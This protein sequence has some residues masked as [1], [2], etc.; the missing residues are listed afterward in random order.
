MIATA[1]AITLRI[2]PFSRTSHVVT[3]L[4]RE[5][6]P[7]ATVVKGAQRPRSDFLGQYD[8]FYTCEILFYTRQRNGLHILRECSP[9]TCRPGFRTNWRAAASASYVAALALGVAPAG[10]V[11]PGLYDVVRQTLDAME[12]GHPSLPVLFWFELHALARIG[13]TPRFNRC[14]ACGSAAIPQSASRFVAS[15]GGYICAGCPLPPGMKAQLLRPDI[16]AVLRRW[17]T[18]RDIRKALTVRITAQQGLEFRRILGMFLDYHLD[19][20]RTGRDIALD[21]LTRRR[22]NDP[23]QSVTETREGRSA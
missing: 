6:G 10:H 16:L 20:A 4:T 7:L 22:P 1:E 12:T 8:L 11:Q 9:L 15:R 18:A 19:T 13:L 3:W 2:S 23:E 5:L 21:L 17:Q 14:L